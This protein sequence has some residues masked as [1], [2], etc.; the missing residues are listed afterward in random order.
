MLKKYSRNG[1]VGD[2][3]RARNAVEGRHLLCEFC[4]R[5][6]VAFSPLGKL[7]VAA[8]TSEPAQ[9]HKIRG[10]GTFRVRAS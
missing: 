6:G 10:R 5:Q 1:N 4:E 2:F 3:D 8:E 7:I 9:L